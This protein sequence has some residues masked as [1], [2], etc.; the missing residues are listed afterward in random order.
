MSDIILFEREIICNCINKLP[1]D[2]WLDVCN[3]P[4]RVEHWKDVKLY[5]SCL[6]ESLS[7][8]FSGSEPSEAKLPPEL[9]DYVALVRDDYLSLYALIRE[10]WSEIVQDFAEHDIE[11]PSTPGEGIKMIFDWECTCLFAQAFPELLPWSNY[12]A[13]SPRKIYASRA[14]ER[15]LNDE[16]EKYIGQSLPLPLRNRLNDRDREVAKTVRRMWGFSLRD[17][18]LS[19]CIKVAARNKTVKRKLY[20]HAE[21]AKRLR[22]E[23]LKEGHPS[24]GNLGW[25]W[26]KGQRREGTK[27]KGFG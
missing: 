18:C 19:V 23:N 25:Q 2:D 7:N 16:L 11:M 4:D 27:H 21:I 13:F 3:T 9:R 24:K 12:E 6:H 1:P 26:V 20:E 8:Y 14:K 10:C 17:N 22:D 5:F 15:K